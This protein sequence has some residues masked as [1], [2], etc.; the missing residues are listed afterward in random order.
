[1]NRELLVEWLHR[2]GLTQTKR[3]LVVLSTFERPIAL[4]EIL[5]RAE[6]AGLK[7]R[8]W[9]NPSA[10]LS[11]TSGMAIHSAKGWEITRAGREMLANEGFSEASLGVI[12]LA[13]D[14]RNYLQRVSDPE[15][16]DYLSEAIR[17]YE[18]G[19]LRS[20]VVMSWLAAVFV[21]QQA[22]VQN[23]LAAFNAEARRV[24]AKWKDAT[25][26]DGLG[27]MKESDF[28]DRLVSIRFIG[29]SVKQ[30]LKECLDRRNACGHPTSLKIGQNIV[31]AHIEALLLNV[32]ARNL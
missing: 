1:M 8:I 18:M 25:N 31:A 14:L 13:T 27:R 12:N 23:H 9:S 26:T 3:L 4:Q 5:D 11:R 2:P 7:R 29:K 15:T 19:L 30:N 21:L 10:S 17:C 20:A 6:E 28:L 16:Q 32:F 24:D 22:I